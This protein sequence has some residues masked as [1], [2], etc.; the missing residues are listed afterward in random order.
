ILLLLLSVIGCKSDGQRRRE[1]N[2]C[3]AYATNERRAYTAPWK[4]GLCLQQEYDWSLEDAQDMEL[5]IA[6]INREDRARADSARHRKRARW[7]S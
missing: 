5:R 2:R 4:V 6:K 7:A 1:I 3:I